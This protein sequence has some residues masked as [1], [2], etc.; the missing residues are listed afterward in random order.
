MFGGDCFAFC[1]GEGS[2]CLPCLFLSARYQLILEELSKLKC[3]GDFSSS[4]K[5]IVFIFGEVAD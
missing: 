4:A 3:G 2:V 5:G 1:A